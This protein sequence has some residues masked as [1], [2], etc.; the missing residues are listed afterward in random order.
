M[1]LKFISILLYS[2]TRS[3]SKS[4]SR[5][6]SKSRHRTKSKSPD[7]SK[8]KL[9]TTLRDGNINKPAPTASTRKSRSRSASGGWSSD[10]GNHKRSKKT[11]R[12]WSRS[13]SPLIPLK[14]ARAIRRA[15]EDAVT[16]EMAEQEKADKERLKQQERRLEEEAAE[17]EKRMEM[18]A[19]GHIQLYSPDRNESHTP[20]PRDSPQ[21]KSPEKT[22]QQETPEKSPPNNVS[23][24]VNE[25]YTNEELT[26]AS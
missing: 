2:S 22:P 8:P 25:I 14:E 11:R 26:I 3:R 13:T 19:N 18:E 4:H 20:P 7:R 17:I 23:E 16:K 1:T 5:S 24:P 10:D 9:V 21:E 12:D 6:R 15:A